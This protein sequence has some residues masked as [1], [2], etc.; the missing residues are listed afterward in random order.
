M[1]INVSSGIYEYLSLGSEVLSTSFRTGIRQAKAL[2]YCSLGYENVKMTLS[3][4]SLSAGS[5]KLG[6]S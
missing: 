1:Q 5:T 4:E 3:H 6:K 2:V